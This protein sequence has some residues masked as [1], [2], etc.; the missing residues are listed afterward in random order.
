[1]KER[2][3]IQTAMVWDEENE[4]TVKEKNDTE[5]ERGIKY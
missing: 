3:E 1:M 5:K 2:K 4:G